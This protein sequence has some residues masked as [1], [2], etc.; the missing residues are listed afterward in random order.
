MKQ[1][2]VHRAVMKYKSE[3]C[4]LQLLYF[5]S[6]KPLWS[7]CKVILAFITYNQCPVIYILYTLHIIIIIMYNVCNI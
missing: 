4:V 5:K 1:W 2:S 3:L 7:L 6:D